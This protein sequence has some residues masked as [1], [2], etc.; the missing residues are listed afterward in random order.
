M[1]N[2][3]CTILPLFIAVA[4]L[5]GPN[6]EPAVGATIGFYPGSSPPPPL[7]LSPTNPTSSSVISYVARTDGIT[8]PNSCYA[9]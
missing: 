6:W 9:A 4:C 8:Y 1:K 3:T 5:L 2:I 7:T